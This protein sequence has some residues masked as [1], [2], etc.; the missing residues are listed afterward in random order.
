[1][2]GAYCAAEKKQKQQYLLVSY[3]NKTK[4]DTLWFW[5]HNVHI[6]G[7]WYNLKIVS[8]YLKGSCDNISDDIMDNGQ[9]EM[10]QP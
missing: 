8:Q 9:Y 7:W 3:K 10:A 4:Q 5:C 1:M 6:K 2:S